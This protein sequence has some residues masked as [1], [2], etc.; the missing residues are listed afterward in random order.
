MADTKKITKKE[1]YAELIQIVE[2]SENDNKGELVDFL[3]KEI[4]ALNKK[5]E[6][7]AE[8]NAKKR[9][10]SD[11]LLATIKGLLTDDLQTTED[12][13]EQLDTEDIT[14]AKVTSRLS[15]LVRE[16]IAE[17]AQTKS[18]DGRRVVAYKLVAEAAE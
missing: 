7:A 16:N 14:K 17:K 10:E 13:L 15:K 11:E 5:A 18:D 12:I 8:A 4:E 1:R 2:A 6:K 3:K 9:A